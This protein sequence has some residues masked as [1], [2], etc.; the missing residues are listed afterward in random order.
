MR[1]RVDMKF[2]FPL[3]G[4]FARYSMTEEKRDRRA[5]A[6]DPHYSPREVPPSRTAYAYDLAARCELVSCDARDSASAC[7]SHVFVCASTSSLTR[8]RYAPSLIVSTTGW[9]RT[10]NLLRWSDVPHARRELFVPKIAIF[11]PVFTHT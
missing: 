2:N 9:K 4:F 3:A 5:R 6:Y 10:F 11:S 1:T 8:T 7:V